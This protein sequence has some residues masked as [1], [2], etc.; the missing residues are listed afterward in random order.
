MSTIS[1]KIKILACI[2]RT[3]QQRHLIYLIHLSGYCDGF[4]WCQLENVSQSLVYP[5]HNPSISHTT[6]KEDF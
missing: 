4:Q 1:Y 3:E 6:G 5:S 2:E